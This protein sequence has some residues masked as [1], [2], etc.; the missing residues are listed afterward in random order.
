[1]ALIIEKDKVATDGDYN[2]SGERYRVNVDSN[3]EWPMAQLGDVFASI[4]NGIN[5][6]QKEAR[7]K[8]KVTRIQTIADGT[9]DLS[10][11]K[12][13][14]DDVPGDRFMQAG[15]ILLSHINSES[16]LAKT[17]IF[18]E[19]EDQVVHGINLLRLCPKK[20]HYCITICT[21]RNEE[22]LLRGPG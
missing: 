13:T 21:L 20:G 15:D 8:Y 7:G 11:T 12:W 9:V 1:M 3:S 10:K 5:V 2:L 17:A 14:D 18:P 4:R 19:C 16:H 6:I 22:R